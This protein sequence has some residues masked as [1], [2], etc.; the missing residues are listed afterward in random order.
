MVVGGAGGWRYE[1]L[2]Q[3]KEW[4]YVLPLFIICKVGFTLCKLCIKL[5]CLFKESIKKNKINLSFFKTRLMGFLP[6][7]RLHEKTSYVCVSYTH[8]LTHTYT[9]LSSLSSSAV[10]RCRAT[11]NACPQ[12]RDSTQLGHIGTCRVSDS[13]VA[14][15]PVY[16]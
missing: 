15:P 8:T 13:S 5:F 10:E 16:R 6:L 2:L 9:H 4:A 14:V 12:S 11:H 3:L 1:V 7:F